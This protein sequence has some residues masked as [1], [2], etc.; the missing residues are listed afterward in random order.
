MM[1]PQNDETTDTDN[2]IKVAI[3]GRVNTGKSSLL[4]ALLKEERSVVSEVDGT[5]IDPIDEDHR[6]RASIAS[7]L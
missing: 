4:N 2:E 3:I 7:P 6:V 5:T 1:N